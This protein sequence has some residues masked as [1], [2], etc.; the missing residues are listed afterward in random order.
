MRLSFFLEDPE[1]NPYGLAPYTIVE[2]FIQISTPGMVFLPVKP[3]GP[4]EH[5]HEGK[6]KWLKYCI[7]E[8]YDVLFVI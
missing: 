5:V 6:T 4:F 8:F 7:P 3:L 2:L 1:K